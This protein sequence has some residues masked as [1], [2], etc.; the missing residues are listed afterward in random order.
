MVREGVK[1]VETVLSDGVETA[2][3]RFNRRAV[4]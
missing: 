3:N 2:M 1:C 4:E